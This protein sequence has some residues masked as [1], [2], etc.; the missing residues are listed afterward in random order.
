MSARHARRF[1]WGSAHY[2]TA[3][4]FFSN[5]NT[6]SS[7]YQQGI[8]VPGFGGLSVDV[9]LTAEERFAHGFDNWAQA[10]LTACEIAMLRL[11][12]D[13]TDRPGWD[14]AVCN[15]RTTIASWR[16]ECLTRDLISDAAWDWCLA[17]LR[18]TAQAFRETRCI[19]V[20]NSASGVCKADEVGSFDVIHALRA[21]VDALMDEQKASTP[22]PSPVTRHDVIDPTM[23]LLAY[24]ATPTVFN[25]YDHVPLRD[26]FS[27][28]G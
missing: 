28:V 25:T 24:G 14:D 22:L 16:N 1:V 5:D 6:D 11:M 19:D 15:E 9:E 3:A 13:L 8:R 20:F 18:D 26:I 23:Y 7:Y 12:N 4:S 2:P 27:S 10:R 17:E 21:G